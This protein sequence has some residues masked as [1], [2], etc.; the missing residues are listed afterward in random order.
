MTLPK[1]NF[2]RMLNLIDEVFATRNDPDQL[3][4]TPQQLKKLE[5][6]HPSTLSE[7]ANE[8]GPLS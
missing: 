3:Q 5:Q 1:P 6:I 4:V 8:D 7:L 2:Q